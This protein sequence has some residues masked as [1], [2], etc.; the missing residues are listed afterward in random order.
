MIL[1]G[2]NLPLSRVFDGFFF[3]LLAG[4][5]INFYKTHKKNR[6]IP[7]RLVALDRLGKNF[8]K[9]FVPGIPPIFFWEKLKMQSA[10]HDR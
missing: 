3:Q 9:K 2:Q 10:N 6:K 5:R 8:W 1:T 4:F 7:H